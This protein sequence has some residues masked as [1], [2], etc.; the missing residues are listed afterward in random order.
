MTHEEMI[1]TFEVGIRLTHESG[2]KSER[3][4][5][6]GEMGIGNTTAASAVAAM[7]TRRPVAECRS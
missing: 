5:A 2:D 4:V 1:A 3:L 7:L 6:V